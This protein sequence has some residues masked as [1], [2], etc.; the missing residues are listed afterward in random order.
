MDNTVT[1]FS[2]G[3][4]KDFVKKSMSKIRQHSSKIN[5]SVVLYNMNA[6]VEMNLLAKFTLNHFDYVID[7]LPSHDPCLFIHPRVELALQIASEN[8]FVRQDDK[9]ASQIAVVIGSSLALRSFVDEVLLQNVSDTLKSKG[10]RIV[11][12][13]VGD[14]SP[15]QQSKFLNIT[16]ENDDLILV[17]GFSTLKDFEETLVDKICSAIGKF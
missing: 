8:I 15:D 17:N 6:T 1:D 7:N 10:V 14:T 12:V 4:Q 5:A 13:L 16:E 2:Y 11:V 3:L 9:N